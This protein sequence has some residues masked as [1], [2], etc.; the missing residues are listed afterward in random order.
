MRVS[1]KW[2]RELV[3]VDLPIDELV[4]LL[5]MTGTKVEAIHTV[6]EALE[7]VLVGRILTKERHPDA[8][9]LWVT[10]VDVGAPA[11]LTIV[12]GAQNF[13][14]GDIVPVA[15]V[16]ATLPNGMTIKKAKLRGVVSEGMNCSGTEL[17][18]GSD[19]SGLLILPP[20]APVGVPF[21]QYR[22]LSD[23]VLELEVTPN[24][25]D[26][27]S[28]AGVAREVGA[29]TD[30][31]ARVPDVAVVEGDGEV[32]D[33]VTVAI[34]D[35]E[36]CPRYTARM[37][38]GVRVGPSPDWL[39]ERVAA[40]GARPVN[41][42]VDV[43]NYVM[44]ELG[45]PLHAF[46][47]ATLVLS[48][49]KRAITVRLA[50]ADEKLT[51]LDGQERLL[52]PDTLVIADPS[53][54]VALAGVMGGAST[55]VTE[56]TVDVLLESA[57]FAP[58]SVGRTSRR[59][60]LI[61]EAS[62]RFERGVDEAGCIIALDRAAALLA[63]VAGGTVE[64]GVIDVCPRPPR[65]AVVPLRV[66]RLNALLG[67]DLSSDRIAGILVRLGLGLE[68]GP[69]DFS[70]TVPTFRPDL[71]R[72]VDLIEE[73]VRV[74]GMGLVPST[75]PAGRGRVGGLTADQRRRERIGVA[76][77]GA[78]LNEAV[79]WSFADP[80]D[81]G[82]TGWVFGPDERPVRL[83]NPMS[84]DQSA[85]RFS[86]L[87]GLLRAV[88]DNR[89]RGV[90]DVHLYEIGAVWWTA[91]GR[92][93]PKERSV[94]AGVL[95]GD[96]DRPGWNDRPPALDI[97]DAKGVVESVVEELGIARFRLRACDLPHLQPGRS[98]EVLVGGDVVGWLGEMHPS[99]LD[100]YECP[101][102]VAVFELQLKPLLKAA[103]D[104]RPFVDLPKFPGVKMDLA[105]V[106][107]DGVP[108]E[109]VEQAIRS[110]GGKLLDEARLFD[111]YRG[112]GVA[113][114][115]TSLAFALV[116]R[117]PE[118]T[119]TDEQVAVLHDKV[120]R[121]VTGAVGGELRGR[122]DAPEPPA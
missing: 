43:T 113:P 39:A 17:G 80:T 103:R 105:I 94:V 86:T 98:A 74:H 121:K 15:I 9:T 31:I 70:V 109:R 32:S 2:L 57:C 59:L 104:V 53:G 26:C 19:G 3:D 27:L 41:N 1:M 87:P 49:G 120:V 90:A 42:V 97:F 46:D 12:C 13:E 8:E 100:S 112:E 50:H 62:M 44:F 33:S 22:G 23:T 29:V 10:T 79:T 118:R 92:K 101:G 36:L 99:V 111:A 88:A 34:E 20:D 58:A 5:D 81:A 4:D 7:G 69:E 115:H 117:D 78:G 38:R 24:R 16:G 110:A 35:G 91:P 55:E 40:A 77:R 114:G 85:L 93:Q 96:W 119:L 82:R 28:M 47:A 51:T 64:R 21:A 73:V 14:A 18:I 65:P 54:A 89:R 61:S 56:N 45:Q 116:Y 75:L 122:Q 37:V 71:E 83:L 95:A 76:L 63:D 66:A 102:P 11:P 60:A 107:S 6:G 48:G 52:A 108:A 25:P 30:R 84:G 72:E 67:T 68:G 106:V